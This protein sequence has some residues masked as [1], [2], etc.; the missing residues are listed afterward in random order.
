MGSKGE[1][2]SRN[3]DSKE[4]KWGGGD[5]EEDNMPKVYQLLK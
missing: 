5:N 3:K 1:K 2:T 4:L